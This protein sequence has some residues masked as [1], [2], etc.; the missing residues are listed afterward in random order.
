MDSGAENHRSMHSVSIGLVREYGTAAEPQWAVAFLRSWLRTGTGLLLGAV[1]AV[2]ELGFVAC[3]ALLM[4]FARAWPR[5]RRSVMQFVLGG[6][7]KL[8]ALEHRR[9][10]SFLDC[11]PV[12]EYDE[13]RALRYLAVR[14]AVGLLG[15]LVL[16]LVL[17]GAASAPIS[18]MELFDPDYGGNRSL[19]ILVIVLF[20]SVLVYVAVQG[21]SGIADLD[22]RLALRFLGPSAEDLLRRRVSQLSSSRAEVVEAVNDERRRIERDLHD[23]VQQRLV[24]LGM[25]IGRARRSR[26]SSSTENLLR[27]AHE[28]AQQALDDLREVAWRV[29]PAALADG[30]LQPALETVAE[31]CGVPV[32]LR[33]ELAVRLPKQIETVG[34]FVVAEAVTNAAKH[35][36][37]TWIEVH[38]RPRTERGTVVVSISDDGTGGADPSGGGLFGLAQRVAALDGTFRVDSPAGGPTTVTA[39]VPCD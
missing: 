34:Y 36:A 13:V 33:Y 6:T 9:L 20:G 32:G 15:G 22:R 37:A 27:Q 26:S 23:G 38:V 8:T 31:R 25:L 17:F 16:F 12:S 11:E 1:S 19:S 2:V 39:E 24:G 7:R 29:Y 21:I 14:W 5:A 3:A 35:A 10:A 4:L 18:I 30:G 28:E